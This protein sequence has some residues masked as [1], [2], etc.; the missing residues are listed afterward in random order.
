MN[1]LLQIKIVDSGNFD[2]SSPDKLA[3]LLVSLGNKLDR[4]KPTSEIHKVNRNAGLK[5]VQV[6][7]ETIDVVS[8]ALAIH[9]KTNGAFD[10]TIGPLVD[11]W[12]ITPSSSVPSDKW[13]P[14]SEK[15]IS[16]ATSLVDGN[17]VKIDDKEIFLPLSG[18]S[19]DLG[20][21]AKGYALEQA[22]DYFRSAGINNFLIDF[23]GNVYVEGLRPGEKPWRVGIRHP[24]KQAEVIAWVELTGVAFSTSG[25]YESYRLY[26]KDRYCHILDPRTG[27]PSANLASV[28]VVSPIPV[29]ADALSTAAFVLGP[30]DG[31]KLIEEWPDAEAIFIDKD[32]H[33]FAT[34]GLNGKVHINK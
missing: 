7:P 22:R 17:K 19:L 20:G 31:L 8:Q 12:Q 30:V 9:K 6:S 13:Q 2:P 3:A 11:L 34:S 16:L 33:V 23:G 21:I 4:F 28:T 26:G 18:M 25:D 14:P 29:Q 5:Q 15:A 32:L 1:T 27:K 10:P 24:Q